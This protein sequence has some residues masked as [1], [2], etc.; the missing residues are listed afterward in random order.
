M[1]LSRKT[2]NRIGERMQPCLTPI[3]VLHH[4]LN[5]PLPV[6]TFVTAFSYNSLINSVKCFPMLN[7]FIVCHKALCQTRSK[8]FLKSMKLWNTYL[9]LSL[10]FS[11]IFLM[12]VISI[13][14]LSLLNPAWLSLSTSS[15]LGCIC[16]C[17]I[18]SSTFKA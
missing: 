12:L 6:M 10:I 18:L 2:L 9:W 4:S 11:L 16:L 7:F 8:A 1:I 13:V 15:I 5:W 17:I 14:L 3:L